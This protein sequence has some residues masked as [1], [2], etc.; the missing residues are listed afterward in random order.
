MSRQELED[1]LNK[2]LYKWWLPLSEGNIIVI[3]DTGKHRLVKSTKKTFKAKVAEMKEK[4]LKY[5]KNDKVI[6]IIWS[7]QSRDTFEDF[8]T[9]L[10]KKGVTDGKPDYLIKNYKKFFT[11]Q[12]FYTDKD[13]VL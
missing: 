12:K 3:Y 4:W 11:R 8:I 13:Y 10:V 2:K 9:M 7:A 6:A 1:E 5:E